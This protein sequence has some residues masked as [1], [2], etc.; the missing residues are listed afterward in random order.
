MP[1]HWI[2]VDG[3]EL[4][5]HGTDYLVVLA[6]A[7]RMGVTIPFVEKIADGPSVCWMGL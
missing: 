4:V 7:R 2:I 1:G 3:E 6:E 5:A